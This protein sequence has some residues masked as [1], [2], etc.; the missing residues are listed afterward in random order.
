MKANPKIIDFSIVQKWHDERM[1]AAYDWAVS[2][3][4]LRGYNSDFMN[5]VFDS[6]WYVNGKECYEKNGYIVKDECIYSLFVSKKDARVILRIDWPKRMVT[7]YHDIVNYESLKKDVPES[8][9]SMEANAL[10]LSKA[11]EHN[12]N[13]Y[14]YMDWD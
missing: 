9:A 4:R 8:V 12:G 7:K 2:E 5:L 3:Q 11:F 10:R 1:E 13:T 14:C 6:D